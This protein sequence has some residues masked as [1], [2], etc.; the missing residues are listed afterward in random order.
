VSAHPS[1]DA[2]RRHRERTA[3][4]LREAREERN[5][6]AAVTALFFASDCDSGSR[7]GEPAGDARC[8][9]VQS[10]PASQVRL[11]IR[12]ACRCVRTPRPTG[13]R[14]T[15]HDDAGDVLDWNECPTCAN[16]T[17]RDLDGRDGRPEAEYV[18][19]E[20]GQVLSTKVRV[21]GDHIFSQVWGRKTEPGWDY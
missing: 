19:D 21:V 12:G 18:C 11:S 17:K 8:E 14:F 6:D 5:V 1:R 10:G 9:P 15:I 2:L 4:T 16:E 3:R 7:D 20:L 13:R